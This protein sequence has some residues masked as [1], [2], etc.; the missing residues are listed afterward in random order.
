MTRDK[1]GNRQAASITHA[2]V[3]RLDNAMA[4]TLRTTNR[5][6]HTCVA[7]SEY[8]L[9]I[10]SAWASLLTHPADRKHVRLDATWRPIKHIHEVRST[11]LE[12]LLH[13]CVSTC[14]E[15]DWGTLFDAACFADLLEN[16]RTH[17]YHERMHH[18]RSQAVAWFGAGCYD[19]KSICQ[20]I[21]Y[22]SWATHTYESRLMQFTVD[23]LDHAL[24][25]GVMNHAY[26]GGR[27]L[28]LFIAKSGGGAWMTRLLK[29]A[30]KHHL[31]YREHHNS[32]AHIM[33]CHA[34]LTT[35]EQWMTPQSG[36]EFALHSDWYHPAH[37]ASDLVKNSKPSTHEQRWVYLATLQQR[38]QK[39]IF[40]MF[41]AHLTID[42]VRFVVWPY[43]HVVAWVS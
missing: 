22:D 35:L 3:K 33:L 12:L 25:K 15:H 32:F 1:T 31:L 4:S 13:F 9:E 29:L 19:L 21:L 42:I 11:L 41:D 30:R 28:C 20:S 10:R 24:D 7:Y 2:F 8:S 36:A 38:W 23:V 34:P 40:D 18:A 5:I 17:R 27:Q 39:A 37:F 26:L 16:F 14:K 43:I 6:G